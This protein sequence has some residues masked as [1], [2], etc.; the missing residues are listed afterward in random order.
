MDLI[1]FEPHQRDELLRLGVTLDAIER[2]ERPVLSWASRYLAKEP[3]RGAVLRELKGIADAVASAH[4]AIEG[5]LDDSDPNPD[6]AAARWYFA[7]TLKR[8]KSDGLRLGETSKSLSLAL[9]LV[10]AAI[11]R[12]PPGPLR[13]KS[14][15]PYPI[16][17]IHK[18]LLGHA[19]ASD[20]RQ[21]RPSVSPTSKFRQVVGICYE[22]IGASSNDPERAIK[23]YL[24]QWKEQVKYAATLENW[25]ERP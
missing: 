24:L 10:N 9:D 7:G 23:A 3:P 12:V 25:T 15:D 20:D 6:R 8:Y 2:L 19:D 1:R 14:A 13:H 18:A 17:Q 16:E 21:F 4:S 11:A 5:I 22:A